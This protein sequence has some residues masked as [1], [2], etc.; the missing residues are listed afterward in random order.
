MQTNKI[1]CQFCRKSY[2]YTGSYLNHLRQNH[3]HRLRVAADAD[4]NAP[5]DDIFYRYE[6]G[7]LYI[8]AAKRQ[9]FEV[10]PSSDQ[11]DID[12]SDPDNDNDNDNDDNGIAR[13][14]VV[15]DGHS[16]APTNHGVRDEIFPDAGNI[17]P[18]AVFNS[19][20]DDSFF[21]PFK[22]ESDY[23]LA[24][25]CILNQVSKAAINDL[26]HLPSVGNI[27]SSTSARML[28]NKID[29]L[30]HQLGMDSW[31][32]AKVSFSHTSDRDDLPDHDLTTF[33]YRDPLKCV[34][35]LMQQTAY[36][37]YM[38][39]AP[40]K[41]FNNMGERMFSEISSG[42]WWWR[43]QV[44]QGVVSCSALINC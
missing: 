9:Q 39:Y 32:Q 36:R 38:A 41:Q 25:W 13:I 4:E 18:G 21:A 26:L 20:E 3:P 14:E 5:H 40:K 34:E 6:D 7:F 22:N 37:D 44:R 23:E 31:K 17:L 42:N 11:S 43:T 29:A 12:C 2:Q 24:R 10:Y 33:W 16:G 19:D 28:F 35:V 30:H 15:P 27:S 1:D 8:P